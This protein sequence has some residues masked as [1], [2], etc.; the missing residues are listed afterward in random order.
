MSHSLDRY[1]KANDKYM[2]ANDKKK[3]CHIFNIGM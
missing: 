3:N 2:E 1:A